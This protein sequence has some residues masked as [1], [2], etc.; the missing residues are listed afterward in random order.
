MA[1]IRGTHP[2]AAEGVRLCQ[3][4][5]LPGESYLIP[6]LQSLPAQYSRIDGWKAPGP[7]SCEGKSSLHRDMAVC[8]T[9]VGVNPELSFPLLL[10]PPGRGARADSDMASAARTLSGVA[11]G[12][13]LPRHAHLPG[14]LLHHAEGIRRTYNQR[15]VTTEALYR[16]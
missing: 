4:L 15:I 6:A 12:R 13:G 11:G 1:G 14:V 8:P 16:L 2:L 5:L 9:E 3:G 7:T 10:L